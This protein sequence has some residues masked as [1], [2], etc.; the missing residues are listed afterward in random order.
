[1]FRNSNMGEDNH[2]HFEKM[3]E[4]LERHLTDHEFYKMY[5]AKGISIIFVTIFLSNVFINIDHGSLPGCSIQIKESLN[6]NDF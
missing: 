5:S 2:K 3:A 1:M 6:M 4:R